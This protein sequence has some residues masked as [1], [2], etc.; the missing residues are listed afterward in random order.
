MRA[1]RGVAPTAASTLL[2]NGVTAR[3]ALELLEVPPGA[4][5]AVI[6]E[7]GAVGGFAVQLAKA[8][9]LTVIADASERDRDLVAALGADHLVP[10]GDGFTDAVLGLR[11][12]GVDGP[13]RHGAVHGGRGHLRP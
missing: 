9:G 7:A 8:A 11:P 4:T 3:Q 6:G 13:D 1:P 5:V 12:D 10:R 2:M